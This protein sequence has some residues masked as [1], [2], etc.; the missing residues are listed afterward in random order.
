MI[1]TDK[2]VKK[3]FKN[4]QGRLD[5]ASKK[6]Q[7]LP[8]G[9]AP[10]YKDRKKQDQTRRQASAEIDHVKKLISYARKYLLEDDREE[11]LQEI[12]KYF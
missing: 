5:A 2:R 4:W 10:S 6:L 12:Q 11:V 8:D 7:K 9:W 3:D 1:P